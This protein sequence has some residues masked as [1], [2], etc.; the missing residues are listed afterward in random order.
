MLCK[1]QPTTGAFSQIQPGWH[2]QARDL[3]IRMWKQ[4]TQTSIS[5]RPFTSKMTAGYWWPL[6]GFRPPGSVG[7][8][9]AFAFENWLGSS[10][11]HLRRGVVCSHD[12][13][14]PGK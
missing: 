1:T 8:W 9:A 11:Q 3:C 12:C 7:A 14:Q 4:T 10:K 2:L 6:R 13:W 5:R